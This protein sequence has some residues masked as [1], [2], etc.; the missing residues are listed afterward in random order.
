MTCTGCPHLPH[1]G[2]CVHCGCAIV[3]LEDFRTEERRLLELV[4]ARTEY[5]VDL[6]ME[7]NEAARRA[8]EEASKARVLLEAHMLEEEARITRLEETV[9]ALAPANGD[10]R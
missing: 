1:P 4:A 5:L 9:A 7:G 6:V 2:A 8:R 10:A 3:T